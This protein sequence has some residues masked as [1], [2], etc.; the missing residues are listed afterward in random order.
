[1]N[2][3]KTILLLSLCVSMAASVDN[4]DIAA[5]I[6]QLKNANKSE[7]YI[8]MNKIK[9]Q[10]AKLN[11]AQRAKAISQLREVMSGSENTIQ[12]PQV[13]LPTMTS[14]IQSLPQTPPAIMPVPNLQ[15]PKGGE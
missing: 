4:I 1:M 2:I 14:P 6:K 13:T 9:M 11:R 15:V 8:I 10:I 5:Q 3:I 7:K 12:I